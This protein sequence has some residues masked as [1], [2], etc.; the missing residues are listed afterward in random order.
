MSDPAATPPAPRPVLPLRGWLAVSHLVVL[1]LPIAGLVGSGALWHDLVNQ[2]RWDL[3]NQAALLALLIEEDVAR[4][5]AP[6][7][8]AS[9]G[10]AISTVLRRAKQATYSGSEVVDAHGVV[11]ATSGR[12]L[13]QDLSREQHVAAALAGVRHQAVKPRPAPS[14][15]QPLTGPSRRARVRVFV[16]HPLRVDDQVVGALVISRTP[17]EEVQAFAQMAPRAGWG[18]AVALLLTLGM[19]WAAGVLAT[20]SLERLDAGAVRIAEGDFGGVDELAEP[21]QSHVAEVSRVARSLTWM[22]TRLRERLHY[23]SEF[24]SN[25]SHEFKTPLATLRGTVELLADDEGMPPEQRERFLANAGKEVDRLER[26]VEGLLSLARADESAARMRLSL[27]ELIAA[28]AERGGVAVE[29]GPAGT[30]V[31]NREQLDAVLHNL[32]GNARAHGGSGV[33]VVVRTWV[34]GARTGFDVIDDGPGISEA[35]L[36]RVFDRFF[37]TARAT[38]GT[39]LGLALVRAIV[40]QHGGEVTAESQPG[41]TRFRVD[42]PRAPTEPPA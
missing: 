5:A 20:R 35:N 34:E 32:V 24:A 27:Q 8:L 18:A 14:K 28:V 7:D 41:R 6:A 21:Q 19:A 23:I 2:T 9:R 42:L 33:E 37:T 25:V 31:G 36:A 15:L 3:E 26:L 16:A 39:G 13:G 17:R 4:Q 29:G 30:V 40:A 38:G 1:V 22:A 11:V 10:P 12:S